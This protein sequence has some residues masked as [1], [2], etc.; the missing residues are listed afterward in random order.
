MIFI[1]IKTPSQQHR[2]KYEKLEIIW[3]ERSIESSQIESHQKIQQYLK[4][5]IKRALKGQPKYYSFELPTQLISFKQKK[6]IFQNISHQINSL[7][8][9]PQDDIAISI[10]FLP[11][12]LH[13]TAPILTFFLDP[14]FQKFH[15][16]NK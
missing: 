3:D 2:T 6:E 10:E 11:S 16:Q 4:R 1:L 13:G 15:L 8:N 9:T 14:K 7:T 5:N 12:I